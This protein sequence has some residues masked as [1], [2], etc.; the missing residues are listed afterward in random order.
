MFIVQKYED[1][2]PSDGISLHT[3]KKCLFSDFFKVRVLWSMVE[4][5]ETII[6]RGMTN[7]EV[8]VVEV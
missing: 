5:L 3:L 7:N 8:T 2:V 6:C 1:M 4:S